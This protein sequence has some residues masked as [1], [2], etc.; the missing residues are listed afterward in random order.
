[1]TIRLYFAF[2]ISIALFLTADL[3]AAPPTGTTVFD[4]QLTVAVDDDEEEEKEDHEEDDEEHGDDE[5]HDGDE[6]GHDEEHDADD[7]EKK[8]DGEKDGDDEEE[9][10]EEEKE[11][12]ISGR[13]VSSQMTSVSRRLEEWSDM[14]IKK[15]VPHGKQVKA[16]D[17]LIEL[18]LTDIDKAI[19]DL[20]H[21]IET[22]KLA[23]EQATEKLAMLKRTTKMDL[24]SAK[25]DNQKAQE[26]LE[27]FR[28]RDKSF[29]IEQNEFSL[30]SSKNRLAYQEEEL[31]QLLKM[32]EADDLTE[33][34]EEIILKR[35]RDQVESA[36]FYLKRYQ[37]DYD[38]YSKYT[39]PRQQKTIETGAEQAALALE[40][41]KITLPASVKELELSIQQQEVSHERSL[42][43]LATLKRDRKEMSIKSPRAGI[44]FYGECENGKFSS[45]RT[46]GKELRKHGSIKSDKVFMTIVTL[47]PLHI[48]ADIGEADL[49][50]V[51][52]GDSITVTPKAFPDSEL[53]A[54]VKEISKFPVDDGKFEV[55]LTCRLGAQ[56]DRIVPG[57]SCD[58][59]VTPEAE[60]GEKKKKK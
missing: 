55:K 38:D 41:A 18:D 34:S 5:E 54:K 48:I 52:K 29:G 12:T 44:V 1:M 15:V 57:M 20:E 59:A 27:L 53:K 37:H 9:E 11:I 23:L 32:Y 47:R 16:G 45:P 36:R 40:K 14:S 17:T 22:D 28:K 21:T 51:K 30:K 33:E 24:E 49:R 31:K 35:T 8:A 13:F 6:D 4:S 26:D 2:L 58:L 56:S 46:L 43:K 10:E 39:L 50:H 25:L 3:S 42:E 7:K 19:S 60:E